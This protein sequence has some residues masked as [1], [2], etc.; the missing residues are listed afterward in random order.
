[1]VFRIEVAGKVDRQR[2]R[3]RIGALGSLP[4]CA[5]IVAVARWNGPLWTHGSL[6]LSATI[7]DVVRPGDECA[8]LAHRSNP[9]MRMRVGRW[10][11][12]G[13]HL[14]K[15]R[16]TADIIDAAGWPKPSGQ[17]TTSVTYAR[18]VP[19]ARDAMESC[20]PSTLVMPAMQGSHASDA[21]E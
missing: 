1:M 17:R 19:W 13:G 9:A 16:W 11:G 20:Q 14:T 7:I 3:P 12:R 18:R 8:A 21:T 6:T 5:G 10:H 2:W 4:L 15:F